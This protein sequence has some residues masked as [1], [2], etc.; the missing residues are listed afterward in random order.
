VQGESS[1]FSVVIASLNEEEGIGP[2]LDEIQRFFRDPRIIVVDGNSHD[3]TLEIAKN[4]GADVILQKG[5]GKGSALFQGLQE[6][7]ASVLYVVFID[8][9]FTYPAEYIPKMIEVLDQ[10]PDVGMVIGDRFGG[11]LN[12]QKSWTNP[13][14]LGNRLIA[15][16]Q[17]TLNGIK[18][19]DP[20]SGLRVVRA[21][22]LRDW[23]PKSKGFDVEA[24]INFVIERKGY[25]IVEIPISYRS[26]LGEKKLKLRHGFQ[27]LKRIV[28]ESIVM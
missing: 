9:D 23:T 26:R 22:A 15:L 20:L 19:S 16:A 21:D 14:Y 8:G 6:L 25:Q 24:E 11:E 10:E 17:H 27:I 1:T 13:F 4:M 12:V 7:P 3:R 2:T 18:L 5:T 28:A